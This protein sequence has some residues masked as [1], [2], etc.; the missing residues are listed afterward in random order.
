MVKICVWCGEPF[1]P[2]NNR[3]L[4]CSKNCQKERYRKLDNWNKKMEYHR[5]KD[6]EKAEKEKCKP[7]AKPKMS[8]NDTQAEARRLG[9]TYGQ[10]VARHEYG[11]R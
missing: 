4:T 2:V 8:I 5:I 10:Y 6:E 1:N 9:L 3:Q 7:I 11:M